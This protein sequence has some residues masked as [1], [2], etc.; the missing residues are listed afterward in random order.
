[1]S[2]EDRLFYFMV[3]LQPWAEQELRRQDSKDPSSAFVAVER[4]VDTSRRPKF[5]YK[6]FDAKKNENYNNNNGSYNKKKFG[7]Q[8]QAS[9]NSTVQNNGNNSGSG[10]DSS[11]N[12]PFRLYQGS[13]CWHC[14]GKPFFS[15]VSKCRGQPGNFIKA[16]CKRDARSGV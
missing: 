6:L 16:S 1:M 5:D 4:L 11:Q 14:S 15:K 3:S 8:S 2:D 13:K 9:S 7:Q 12:K 10:R